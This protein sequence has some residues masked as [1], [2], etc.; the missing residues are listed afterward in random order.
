MCSQSDLY[1]FWDILTGKLIDTTAIIYIFIK[2]VVQ[3]C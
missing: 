1:I 3:W 2:V